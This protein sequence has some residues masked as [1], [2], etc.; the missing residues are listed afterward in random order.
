MVRGCG[1]PVTLA[2]V[3]EHVGSVRQGSAGPGRGDDG[4]RRFNGG[5]LAQGLLPI[6]PTIADSLQAFLRPQGGASGR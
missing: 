3:A 6:D 5:R 2:P 1:W 4:L